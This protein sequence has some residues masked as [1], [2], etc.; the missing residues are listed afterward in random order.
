MSKPGKK[1]PPKKAAVFESMK[2]KIKAFGTKKRAFT[3]RHP[4]ALGNSHIHSYCHFV[5]RRQDI[6]VHPTFQ[7]CEKS[8]HQVYT[9]SLSAPSQKK[10]PSDRERLRDQKPSRDGHPE[11]RAPIPDPPTKIPHC[12]HHRSLWYPYEHL[13]RE[14]TRHSGKSGTSGKASQPHLTLVVLLRNGNVNRLLEK[15]LKKPEARASI[16]Q[17][18]SRWRTFQDAFLSEH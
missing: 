8:T 6:P 10:N 16:F 18:Y 14:R 9:S 13:H 17:W 7:P 4:R 12:R 2:K 5:F 3:K 15:T 1:Q 11:G